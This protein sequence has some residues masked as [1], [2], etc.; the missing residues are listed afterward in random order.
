MTARSV[1]LVALFAATAACGMG[2]SR[3]APAEVEELVLEVIAEHPHDPAA[4]TQGLVWHEGRLYE[5]TGEYGSSTLRRL[6]LATGEVEIQR[7][8]EPTMFG[9]GLERVGDRLIQL[10]WRENVA[11]VYDLASLEPTGRLSYLGEGWGLCFDDVDLIR[12]DGSATLTVHDAG[13]LAPL[14]RLEVTFQGRP[15]RYLNELECVHGE[16]WANVWQTDAIV[17]IDPASGEVTARVDASSLRAR[18]PSGG[19]VLNGIAYRGERG[20][21]LVTG[22]NWGRLFEV[23][24]ATR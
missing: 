5:S 12:S 7:D 3:Q 10:T 23:T 1:A 4:F 9:E 11:L 13:T 18:L 2:S 8:L 21:F 20:T 14:R 16:V 24:W 17:R 6:N 15:V 22:K 19:G